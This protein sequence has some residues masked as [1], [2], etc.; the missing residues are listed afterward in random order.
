MAECATCGRPCDDATVCAPCARRVR[1]A[2]RELAGLAPELDV[3][4]ARLGRSG[5]GGRGADRHPLPVDLGASAQAWA[6]VNTVVTW[7]RDTARSR[8]IAEL[9][10]PRVPGPVCRTNAGVP[11]CE[12][13]SCR[14]IARS[15]QPV[16]EL[17]EA[18]RWLAGQVE[19]LRHQPDAVQAMDELADACALATRIVDRRA[20]RWYAGPCGA[21]IV[22][23]PDESAADGSDG[24]GEG[25]RVR[26]CA[27]DLYA[28]AGARMITCGGCGAR[29]DARERRE[30]LL[31]EA[32]DA[33]V[34]AE[35]AAQALAAL[36]LPCTRAQ[37]AG[38]AHR[39]RL[40]R[41]GTDGAGRTLYRCGD[42]IEL[43]REAAAA[44]VGGSAA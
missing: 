26:T 24:A 12:H 15:G 14:T 38:W 10:Y 8:G 5:S 19:W 1:D 23:Q 4:I 35:L 16:D 2:L 41:R 21:E 40:V 44:K 25:D 29:Y 9:R 20:P 6:V 3:T 37:V 30:W 7:I 11:G 22:A 27:S 39:G 31:D 32:E 34:W 13:A 18:I 33:L 17:A 42:V 43:A 28:H 36:D